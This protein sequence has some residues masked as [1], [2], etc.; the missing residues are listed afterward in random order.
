MSQEVELAELRDEL[1]ALRTAMRAAGGKPVRSITIRGRL[2]EFADPLAYRR[3]LLLEIK[4]LER[5][6]NTRR[7]PASN[8]VRLGRA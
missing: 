4:D 3:Q 2:V 7:G 1:S 8:K 5:T 6:L